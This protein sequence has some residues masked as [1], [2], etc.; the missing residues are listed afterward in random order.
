M[1]RMV[2]VI[3][4]QICNRPMLPSSSTSFRH[5]ADCAS[6]SGWKDL[7]IGAMVD[8]ASVHQ[9]RSAARSAFGGKRVAMALRMHVN[10]HRQ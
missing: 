4:I 8:L 7:L 6:R 3:H 2:A 9:E 10:C 5:R 1:K